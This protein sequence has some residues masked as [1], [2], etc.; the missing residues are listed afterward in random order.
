MNEEFSQ[1]EQMFRTILEVG[2]DLKNWNDLAFEM[3]K[4][5]FRNI[6]E[7]N[8]VHLLHSIKADGFISFDDGPANA[9]LKIHLTRIGAARVY[10]LHIPYQ[11]VTMD[12]IRK[13]VGATQIEFARPYPVNDRKSGPVEM[14][15]PP[16]RS[17]AQNEK[18][19]IEQTFVPFKATASTNRPLVLD[20]FP[21]IKRLMT[22]EEKITAAAKLLE[23]AG[24]EDHAINLLD[25]RYEPLER[26]IL[27]FVKRLEKH[28]DSR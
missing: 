5:G 24:M 6:D 25:I 7:H 10:D 18:R 1:K 19:I 12:D 26:E 13:A 17:M 28:D 2:R 16:Q 4:R 3:S 8:G 11:K 23:E 9:V 20:E 22:R 27:A 15:R 14:V 21:L